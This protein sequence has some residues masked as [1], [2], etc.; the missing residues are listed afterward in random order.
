VEVDC[1]CVVPLE[2][3]SVAFTEGIGVRL[4][5]TK[6][7]RCRQIAEYV[8][9]RHVVGCNTNR[10]PFVSIIVMNG[11]KNIHCLENVVWATNYLKK[12]VSIIG[13]L[14]CGKGKRNRTNI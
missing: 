9:R 1:I 4:E 11:N 2:G 5:G 8:C 6:A 3:R 12:K 13:A 10:G 14:S 7:F